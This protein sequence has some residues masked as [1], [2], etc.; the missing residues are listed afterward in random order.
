M[1]QTLAVT[2]QSLRSLGQRRA[3]ALVSVVGVAG[4]VAV[5]VAVLSMAAGFER[6]MAAAGSDLNIIVL[7][8][9]SS[10]EL[11]SGLSSE[12]VRIIKD[13]PGLASG[14]A[15]PIVSAELYVIVDLPKKSTLTTAN[16]PL[17]GIEPAAAAIREGLTL[18]QGRWFEPGKMELVAGRGAASQ[19]VGL[20][21]GNSLKFG[22]NQWQVVGIFEAGGGVSE[23]ELWADVKVVQPAYRRGNRFAS[24]YARL[25]SSEALVSV[26]DT[27]STDPRL[28]VDVQLER[29]YFSEQSEALTS[30]IS[31]AGYGI[32]LLMALGAAFGAIN[33]MYTTVAA[34]NREI[35][36][37]KA[38]GFGAGPIVISVLVESLLLSVAGGLLGGGL[39]WLIFNGFTVSTLN[40][41][42]FSQVVFA[43]SVTSSLLIRGI[44]IALLIGLIAGFFPAI[45]AARRPVSRALREP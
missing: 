28:E 30:F 44:V 16:V 35:A 25:E 40:F 18:T 3:N 45:S 5:F 33:T 26:R 15:G 2:G 21:I 12:Q 34:R 23:S 27:L 7:R 22:Q 9:N 24:V 29:E 43:F 6:T 19:F 41:T 42:G 37:L 1:H 38:L 17:R 31:I 36:T 8:E 13:S 20:E 11:D 32:A 14:E 10:S 4:V 39:A